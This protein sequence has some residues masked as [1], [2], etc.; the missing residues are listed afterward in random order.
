LP[1]KV[2]FGEII[3]EGSTLEHL[4]F[5]KKD[6][7]AQGTIF[8][9]VIDSLFPHIACAGIAKMHGTILVQHLRENMLTTDCNHVKS[10]STML[11]IDNGSM[12]E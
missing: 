3:L 2:K 11:K 6:K 4:L 9:N 12:K 1:P 7:L 10:S 8:L 5:M